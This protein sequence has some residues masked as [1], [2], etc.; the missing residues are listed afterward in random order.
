M[1]H[2]LELG[3]IIFIIMGGEL[4]TK[5]SFLYFLQIYICAGSV[6]SLTGIQFGDNG[7][8]VYVTDENGVAMAT[9]QV[10]KSLK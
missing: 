8:Q 5:F 3:L 7:G 4:K 10:F 2:Y 1:G 9:T 6:S